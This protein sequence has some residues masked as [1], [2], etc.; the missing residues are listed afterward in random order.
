MG[1]YGWPLS[2]YIKSKIWRGKADLDVAAIVVAVFGVRLVGER[3]GH[4][5]GSMDALT[6]NVVLA[7]SG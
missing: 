6:P 7:C 3:G 1:P 4:E 5:H 2:G